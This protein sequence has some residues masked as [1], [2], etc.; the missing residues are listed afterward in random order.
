MNQSSQE[1][2]PESLD[3][4]HLVIS[5]ET[6]ELIAKMSKYIF[7]R[8]GIKLARFDGFWRDFLKD[9]PEFSHLDETDLR[10]AFVCNLLPTPC[11]KNTHNLP[12]EEFYYLKLGDWDP[13]EQED[14]DQE[15][16]TATDVFATVAQKLHRD[17]FSNLSLQ[18]FAQNLRSELHLDDLDD[19]EETDDESSDASDIMNIS[20]NS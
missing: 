11:G 9:F 20:D 8:Q 10:L 17:R 13:D 4:D 15:A 16:S 12:K 14:S 2:A 1:S 6:P 19:S 3:Q 18:Q 5:H 7:E